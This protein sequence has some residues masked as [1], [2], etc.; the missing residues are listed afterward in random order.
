MCVVSCDFL[1]HILVW[2]FVFFSQEFAFKISA[3][4]YPCFDKRSSIQVKESLERIAIEDCKPRTAWLGTTLCCSSSWSSSLP[5]LLFV[6]PP[7]VIASVLWNQTETAM[8]FSTR[9]LCIWC[10]TCALWIEPAD[11]SCVSSLLCVCAW[12]CERQSPV[13]RAASDLSWV[14]SGFCLIPVPSVLDVG[15]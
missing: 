8:D 11:W 2:F 7:H 4:A 6:L 3:I 14:S 13:T 5:V 12:Q 15:F 10:A 1:S 9:F